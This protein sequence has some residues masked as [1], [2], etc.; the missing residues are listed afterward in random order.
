MQSIQGQ[1]IPCL[2]SLIWLLAVTSCWLPLCA[3]VIVVGL[4]SIDQPDNTL[5][6]YPNSTT[7]YWVAFNG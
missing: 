6:D 3:L 5:F 2:A 4:L 1:M 7:N